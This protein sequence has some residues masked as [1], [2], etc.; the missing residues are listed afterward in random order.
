MG[1]IEYPKR[2]LFL[3]VNNE[4][5]LCTDKKT[6]SIEIRPYDLLALDKIVK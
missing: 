2:G 4:N 3:P 1:C 6:A 5:R